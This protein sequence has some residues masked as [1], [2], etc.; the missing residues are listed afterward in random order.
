MG[1]EAKYMHPK[2]DEKY[3]K[4]AIVETR[5]EARELAPTD[6]ETIRREAESRF[7]RRG[8]PWLW[9]RLIDSVSK[10]RVDGWSKATEFCHDQEV[11]LFL[12][13]MNGT[14]MWHFNS[15][16]ELRVVLENSPGFE[17]YLTDPEVTYVLC[18]NHHDYLIGAGN[19]KAWLHTL[20]D[21]SEK[22]ITE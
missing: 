3:I 9:D 2:R 22:S 15:G 17:F 6:A 8:G 19:C 13:E 10:Y 21:D 4:D 18:H 12:D 11:T 1:G 7:A 16:R 5:T 20:A 14:T